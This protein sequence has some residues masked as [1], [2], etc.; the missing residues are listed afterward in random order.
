MGKND[1]LS[2]FWWI[3][4]L[5][6]ERCTL[7]LFVWNIAGR[8]ELV[9]EFSDYYF[10]FHFYTEAKIDDRS[11]L[12]SLV[13]AININIIESIVSSIAKIDK[14][15]LSPN[16]TFCT[17]CAFFPIKYLFFRKKCRFYDKKKQ[18]KI[19]FNHLFFSFFKRKNLRSSF[20]HHKVHQMDFLAIKLI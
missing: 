19:N 10:V 6:I 12:I 3:V 4:R 13:N 14:N 5:T 16:R 8:L 18:N 9:L 7:S 1:I 20:C 11:S 15:F 17:F 2:I